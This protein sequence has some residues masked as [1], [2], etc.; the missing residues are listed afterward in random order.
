VVDSYFY[1]SFE[2]LLLINGLKQLFAFGYSYGVIP[3][4]TNSGYQNAF[5]AM[6]GIQ[7]GVML[8]CLPLWYYG[9]QIRKASMKWKVIYVGITE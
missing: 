9:K 8:F 2:S 3:W 6:A 7:V 1:I 4:I 5:G